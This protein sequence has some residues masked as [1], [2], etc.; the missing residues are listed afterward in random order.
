LLKDT[1]MAKKRN[2]D[3]VFLMAVNPEVMDEKV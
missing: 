3:W 1:T 2:T